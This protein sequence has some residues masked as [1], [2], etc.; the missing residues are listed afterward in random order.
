M[1][2]KKTAQPK[3]IP[4]RMCIGCRE[5]L[6]KRSLVRVVRGPE[7]IHIDPSGK[8]AGRGAYIHDRRRCWER[9]LQGALSQALKA[10]I[11]P[12]ER[13]ALESHKLRLPPDEGLETDPPKTAGGAV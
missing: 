6:A 10:E 2:P 3:H 11:T 9:A 1:S 12:S 4:L 13:E 8:A 5:A 7:G